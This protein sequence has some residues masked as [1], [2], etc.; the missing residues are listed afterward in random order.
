MLGNRQNIALLVDDFFDGLLIRVLRVMLFAKTKQD[1]TVADCIA[2]KLKPLRPFDHAPEMIRSMA[3][4]AFPPARILRNGLLLGNYV[5]KFLSKLVRVI[6][7]LKD[8][9]SFP[10]VIRPLQ[11]HISDA[12]MNLQTTLFR[13]EQSDELFSNCLPEK[14]DKYRSFLS[15][16]DVK[17]RQ[18][19]SVYVGQD[20]LFHGS[21]QSYLYENHDVPK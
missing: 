8:S 7:R 17:Q 16:T 14:P 5:V 11:I 3:I 20:A 18:Q 1:L 21:K 6:E 19:R 15:K 4:R 10:Q 2:S 9:K 12:V 13:M